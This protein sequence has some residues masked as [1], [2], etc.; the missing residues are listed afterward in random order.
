MVE[1]Y[2][3]KQ[4][5]VIGIKIV[6]IGEN[7]EAAQPY[8][9]WQNGRAEMRCF[10]TESAA[11]LDFTRRAA[12]WA[13]L[14]HLM[15]NLDNKPARYSLL[16]THMELCHIRSLPEALRETLFRAGIHTLGDLIK[17]LDLCDLNM[18]SKPNL[19]AIREAI[20]K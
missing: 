9:T 2:K 12:N 8:A 3:V 20:K 18:M 1:Q 17:K 16:N 11:M 19:K 7:P 5:L 4:I 15:P 13:R 14:Q 10:D 6:F